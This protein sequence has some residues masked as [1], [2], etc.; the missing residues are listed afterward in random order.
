[1]EMINSYIH[2]LLVLHNCVIVP[3]LGGFI[4]NHQ[5]AEITDENIFMPPFRIIAF[6]PQ[7][8]TSDGL[9]ANTISSI[10]HISYDSAVVKIADYVATI[11]K[12]LKSEGVF[13]LPNIGYLKSNKEGRVSFEPYKKNELSAIGLASFKLRPLDKDTNSTSNISL[14]SVYKRWLIAGVS[15]IAL[16][17]LLFNQG[18][19]KSSETLASVTPSF[20][21]EPTI[22][23]HISKTK[24]DTELV[25]V[26]T[27]TNKATSEMYVEKEE[28]KKYHVVIGCFSMKKNAEKQQAIF[29]ALNYKTRT[30]SH[31]NKFTG[32]SVG[33]FSSFDEARELMNELRNSGTANSAWILKK[34]F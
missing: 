18:S 29:D 12:G 24:A 16:V 27:A 5:S 20:N 15:G 4:T 23:Q 3:E 28:L 17:S 34:V 14:N 31:R 7:L 33:S 22:S 2:D 19:F 30:F 26:N 1:M 11:Q 8:T 32:V 10:E 21:S 9:L 25:A 6:N 13:M